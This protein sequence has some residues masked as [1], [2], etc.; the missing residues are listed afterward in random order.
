MAGTTLAAAAARPAM[1]MR[2]CFVGWANPTVSEPR[3]A[4]HWEVA[5]TRPPSL[6][7]APLRRPPS[8]FGG[9]IRAARVHRQ[10]KPRRGSC[11]R[12]VNYSSQLAEQPGTW[13]TDLTGDMGNT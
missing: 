13:V 12:E 7:C 8:P 2:M 4:R 6:R 10:D 3:T 11:E 9:G 5:P 1:T